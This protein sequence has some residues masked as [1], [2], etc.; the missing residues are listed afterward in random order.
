VEVKLC[1]CAAC[2]N[3]NI[4]FTS[5]AGFPFATTKPGDVGHDLF[6]DI[7]DTP[8]TKIDR[9][10]SRLVDDAVVVIWPFRNKLLASGIHLSMP[11][12]VWAKI[13]ARSSASKKQLA[14]CG[15]VIDSG[16]RGP[17]FA[18]M[19][20]LSLVP[21]IVRH[22]ERYAQ[23]IFHQAVRPVATKVDQFT[24]QDETARGDTGFGS[25]GR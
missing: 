20:N 5:R 21:R 15:G 22:G 10:V 14:T 18:V 16:Y 23:A 6:V 24:S 8:T 3:N 4:R 17:L 13:E 25:S 2:G 19:A 12:A 9:L 11:E 7:Y 1:N